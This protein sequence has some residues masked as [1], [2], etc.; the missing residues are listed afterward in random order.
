[1][2]I[3]F[4]Q[5]LQIKHIVLALT[6]GVLALTQGVSGRDPTYNGEKEWLLCKTQSAFWIPS[7][8]P[9]KN[10][11]MLVDPRSFKL[12]IKLRPQ[13]SCFGRGNI[14]KQHSSSLD[15]PGRKP[16]TF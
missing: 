3:V 10:N 13:L 6:Q 14:V 1:M 12:Q 5:D 7:K 8:T 11:K 15:V 9:E 16:S 2:S 4:S